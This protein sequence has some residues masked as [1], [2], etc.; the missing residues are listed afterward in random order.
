MTV[1]KKIQ[2]FV[3]QSSWI[4]KMFEEGITLK[5]QYGAENVFDF[6]LGNPNIPPPPEFKGVLQ[7]LL[8]E[9]APNMHGYMPN[10]GYD[11]TR[12]AVAA[13]IRETQ[14]VPL[15]KE[16]IVMT[17]GAAGALNV[18]LKVILDPLD[19]VIVPSPFF[20]EYRFYIDNANGK[21]ILVPTREDF[22]LD[23]EA[24]EKAVTEKTKAIILNSPNNPSGKIYD[25]PSLAAL[26]GLLQKMKEKYGH[27]V[28]LLVDE[29]Y[30][31]I[32]FDGIQVPSL[33]NSYPHCISASSYSKTLSIPGER[34][35]Y[36]AVNPALDDYK[37]LMDGLALYNRVL[38]FVN[39][40]AFM[41]R[42]I[43]RM[44]GIYVDVEQYKKKRD[45]LCEGLLKAGYAIKKPEGAFY[46][47]LKTPIED[48]VAFVRALQKYRILAVPGQGFGASG[49]IRLAFCVDDATIT[50]A[51]DGFAAALKD[52]Q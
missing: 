1:A 41:Q 27:T 7:D 50:R 13:Y 2:E 14:D 6:T 3:S 40:P 43:A 19:E 46:L 36:L 16:H 48:D 49:Y 31:E 15:E 45:L 38:G 33:L 23:M 30:R 52:C 28:Y 22:S 34:I 25:A 32:V 5:Q 44:Q 51:M 26:A 21:M 29:P 12:A 37:N 8:D 42:A 20:M 10:I 18:A 11:D 35:G 9:G 47:F 39:A 17:C 4:R 24:I